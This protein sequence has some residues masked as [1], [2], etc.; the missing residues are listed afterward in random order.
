MFAPALVAVMNAVASEKQGQASGI[1][2]TAQI[3]G[4]TIGLAVLSALLQVIH[5]YRVIFLTT[6][7]FTFFTLLVA[8]LYLDRKRS[9]QI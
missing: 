5:D 4:A 2:L 9:A 7:A 3:F 6:G 8:W 1:V